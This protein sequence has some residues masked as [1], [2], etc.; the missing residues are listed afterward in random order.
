MRLLDQTLLPGRELWIEPSGAAQTAD[1]IRRLA[2]RGAPLIGIAAAYG[3]AIEV[4]ADPS[5]ESVERA[6]RELRPARPTAVN[7]AHAVDRVHAA[8]LGAAPGPA[9]A[10]AAIAE[11]EAIHAEEDAATTRSRRLAPTCSP[12][13]GASSR[14]ATPAPSRRAAGLGAGACCS[15][16]TLAGPA[17]RCSH[18][19]PVRC[20]RAP[21]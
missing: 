20:C 13:R 2:V 14:T 10:E 18:A 21:A 1:A 3:M 16:C 17:W 7:L 19:R 11:A 8:A 9:M 15:S 6:A 4:A 5:A 12:A